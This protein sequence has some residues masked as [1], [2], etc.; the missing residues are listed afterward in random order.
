MHSWSSSACG[1]VLFTC[2]CSAE[3]GCHSNCS[4]QSLTPRE[5]SYQREC[6]GVYFP[7]SSLI[8]CL[9]SS[10]C[11]PAPFWSVCSASSSPVNGS[12]VYWITSSACPFDSALSVGIYH[13]LHLPALQPCSTSALKSVDCGMFV[14]PTQLFHVFCG[15]SMLSKLVNWHQC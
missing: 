6:F 14:F 2:F 1:C 10:Y 7:L 3:S 4:S 13:P 12:A 5:T 9:S 15:P 8:L 11:H